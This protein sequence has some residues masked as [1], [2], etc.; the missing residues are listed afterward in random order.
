MRK[1]I[2]CLLCLAVLLCVTAFAA[3]EKA[4]VAFFTFDNGDL[5]D[6]SGNGYHGMAAGAGNLSFV[7]APTRG[8]VLEL[9]NRGTKR[10][11]G[12]SGFRIP[13]DGLKNA[14]NFTIVMDMYVQTEGTNQNWFDI[15]AGS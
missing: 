12:S 15:S 8:G 9:N 10:N 13:T 6:S 14:K 2:I 5:S 3:E 11:T 4:P 7:T 1:F